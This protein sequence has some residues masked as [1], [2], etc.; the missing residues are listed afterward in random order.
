MQAVENIQ[1]IR[2]KVICGGFDL[3]AVM[4]EI[5]RIW[6]MQYRSFQNAR[7]NLKEF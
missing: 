1:I 7:M 5:S 2:L 6:I 3:I 4:P